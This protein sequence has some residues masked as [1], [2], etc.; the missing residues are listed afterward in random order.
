MAML[1]VDWVDKDESS[2]S[3]KT[4]LSEFDLVFLIE[5]RYVNNNCSLEQIIIKQHGL[6]GKSDSENQIRSI[7][8]EQ[9]VLLI[10]DG[11]DEYQKGT[12]TIVKY[13]KQ[14][15]Q[16]LLFFGKELPRSPLIHSTGG[17]EYEFRSARCMSD[18][19]YEQDN[20]IS[21]RRNR[22]PEQG[23]Q[24]DHLVVAVFRK[25]D[26]LALVYPL[27]QCTKLTHL[28]YIKCTNISFKTLRNNKGLKA[29]TVE[30]CRLGE[31]SE[32]ELY[33]QLKYLKQLKQISFMK[34][35]HWKHLAEFTSSGTFS[36]LASLKRLSLQDCMLTT[37]TMVALMKSLVQC[38]LLE[39]DLS[40]NFLNEF[41]SKL[42]QTPDITLKNLERINCNN[43]NI[44]KSD[45]MAFARLIN[46]NRVPVIKTVSMKGN[47]L[48]N[49]KVALEEHEKSCEHF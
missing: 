5:L 32:A 7:L 41:I 39:L 34:M 15:I 23:I 2:G 6:K 46:E 48:A 22:L 20:P 17:I 26:C 44:L 40:D 12:K 29:L 1:A 13:I 24:L 45:I 27:E 36:S 33:A 31:K 43:S 3:T 11:Y 21:A 10:L 8:E 42:S 35:K 16:R 18:S 37:P 47:G 25:V 38:P 28:T 49:H 9:S 4:K 19:L 14:P 30:K